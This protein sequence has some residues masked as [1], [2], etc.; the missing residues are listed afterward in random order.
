MTKKEKAQVAELE[1]RLARAIAWRRTDKIEPDIPI[2]P[3]DA[4]TSKEDPSLGWT[5]WGLRTSPAASTL[6]S[7]YRGNDAHTTRQYTWS[8]NGI[9]MFSTELLAAKAARHEFEEEALTQLVR[10]DM[11]IAELEGK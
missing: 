10:H 1:N 5:F 2:P 11:K 9:A 4:G 3:Y 7:H 6:C 8:Q